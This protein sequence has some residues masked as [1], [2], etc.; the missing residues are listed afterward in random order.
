MPALQDPTAWDI[1]K[2]FLTT[3]LTYGQMEDNFHRY[4]GNRHHPLK[5]TEA[6]LAL[7]LGNGNDQCQHIL[8]PV[9]LASKAAPHQSHKVKNPFINLKTEMDNDDNELEDNEEYTATTVMRLSAHRHDLSEAIARIEVNVT[10]SRT[11]HISSVAPCQMTGI[12]PKTRM[13]KFILH[14]KHWDII[15]EEQEAQIKALSLQFPFPCWLRVK[16][17]KYRDTVG[18]LFDSE[19]SNNFVM[20]LIPPRDFPYKMPK[21]SVALFNPSRLLP[22]ISMM[23]I[24]CD[25][26]IVRQKYKARWDTPFTQKVIIAF[27][28]L[29]LQAGD[30]VHLHT[31]DL[32]GQICTVLSTDHAFGG[33]IDIQFELDS[34]VTQ[35]QATLIDIEYLLGCIRVLRDTSYRASTQQEIEVSKYY[36]DC[37]PI[38]CI[39]QAYMLAPQYVNPSEEPK[40]IEI[41]NYITVTMGDLIGKSD[42]ILWATREFIW[43]QD[44]TDLQR[45]NDHSDSATPFLHIIVPIHFMM[46]MCNIDL[47]DFKKFLNKEPAL[48]DHK[49]IQHCYKSSFQTM[50]LLLTLATLITLCP[51]TLTR[52]YI[53]LALTRRLIQ[54]P[55]MAPPAK[56]VHFQEPINS[57][58]CC[59]QVHASPPP[60]YA[61]LDRKLMSAEEWR[62]LC[63]IIPPPPPHVTTI[64]YLVQVIKGCESIN[65]QW[66][67]WVTVVGLHKS[68]YLV[69]KP[70]EILLEKDSDVLQNS[71]KGSLSK[72]TCQIT[73]ASLLLT[74]L[75]L[76]GNTDNAKSK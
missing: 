3:V 10:S 30:S 16:C 34:V 25:G 29:S 72:P 74:A 47:D 26:E 67:H 68:K 62:T 38:Y 9:T 40:I 76:M 41:S 56:R 70:F 15:M 54:T 6:R 17:G 43:L 42:L 53:Q 39:L 46:K 8:P 36:L 60:P 73:L 55:G 31:S 48:K 12:I 27:S 35:M 5:W 57:L 52:L 45:S 51:F 32:P 22:G 61:N 13:Y 24:T 1:L 20:V 33:M 11:N 58:Y 63:K 69:S 4:L 21:G 64:G 23:D 14:V 37:H 2:C 66:K 75:A 28:K 50:F 59:H 71:V 65:N 7:F 44:D 49:V 19:Q 18:Y